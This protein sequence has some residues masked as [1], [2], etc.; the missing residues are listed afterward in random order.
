MVTLLG[1]LGGLP[2]LFTVARRQ[3]GLA[4][5]TMAQAIKDAFLVTW[6]PMRP[7]RTTVSKALETHVSPVVARAGDVIKSWSKTLGG[8]ALAGIVFGLAWHSTVKAEQ[9]AHVHYENV[10]NIVKNTSS[11]ENRMYFLDRA[12]PAM[13]GFSFEQGTIFS[14]VLPEGNLKTK[15]GICPKDKGMAMNWLGEFRAAL[16]TC[17]KKTNGDG[18][19]LEMRAYSSIAPVIAQGT[20]DHS[21]ELNCAIANQRADAVAHLLTA[22]ES[23]FNTA[24]CK[25]RVTCIETGQA[26]PT[27]YGDNERV[28]QGSNFTLRYRPW[29]RFEDMH[30]TRPMDD[31]GKKDAELFNR[32]VQIIVKNNACWRDEHV[33]GGTPEATT[34]NAEAEAEE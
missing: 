4:L 30:E 21:D 29:K 22:S 24:A 2:A 18:L 28:L 12:R 5:R 11:T 19:E 1:L 7:L 10:T 26:D 32:V 23:D 17:P 3:L 15:A 25:T 16:A 31:A 6:F 8:L 34:T 27:L 13:D 33:E 20:A 14:L 9:S